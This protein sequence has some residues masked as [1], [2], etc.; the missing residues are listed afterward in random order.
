MHD[1]WR[2]LYHIKVELQTE[3]GRGPE[4]L[5]R[6]VISFDWRIPEAPMVPVPVLTRDPLSSLLHGIICL[7]H[8]DM[9]FVC[10]LWMAWIMLSLEIEDWNPH[11]MDCW[12]RGEKTFRV[13]LEIPWILSL[14]NIEDTSDYD[15][16]NRFFWGLLKLWV[17]LNVPS[18]RKK[19]I[20]ETPLVHQ[21][22]RCR[23]WSK[24]T[25]K[26]GLWMIVDIVDIVDIVILVDTIVI[27]V[28][29]IVIF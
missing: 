6:C 22:L 15:F 28:D 5:L 16:F 26:T 3:A 12:G 25:P 13:S 27:L 29:T 8:G 21:V 23:S 14:R 7:V 18:E 19:N 17:P 2:G 11:V 4:K 10:G 20:G 9:V 1:W 24:L